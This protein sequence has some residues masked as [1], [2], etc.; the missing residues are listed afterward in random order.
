MKERV[1]YYDILRG[2]AIIGVV[3]IHSSSIGYESDSKNI[4]FIATILWRQLINFSV[5][6]FLTISGFLLADKKTECKEDYFFF[7]RRQLARVLFPYFC[8]S[9]VYLGISLLDGESIKHAIWRLIS[10]QPVGPFYFILL[11][12]QYYLLLP[13][14]K[15]IANINGL[16]IAFLISLISCFVVFYF[17]YYSEIPLPLFVYGGA[18]STWLIF[19]VLGIYLRRN[20]VKINNVQ[21]ILG[22]LLSYFISIGETFLTYLRFSNIDSAVTQVKAS[23]FL[24]SITVILFLFQNSNRNIEHR[25]LAYL[26]KISFGIY[27]SH[28]L[29][30]DLVLGIL[31]QILPQLSSFVLIKQIVLLCATL[32]SC[33]IFAFLTKT[34][35]RNMALKYLGQ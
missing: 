14:L 4:D 20:K 12:I 6:L 19:F 3:A 8:W 24:Y 18:S 13:L 29:F 31:N 11:I 1:P 35:D 28:M 33:I 10:F 25:F 27:L 30:L 7:I 22:I 23:S 15:K 16:G 32:I 21:L 26:G 5:P 34:I 2:V 17:R 9:I